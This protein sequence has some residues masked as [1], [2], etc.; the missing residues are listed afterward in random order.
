MKRNYLFLGL[1]LGVSC[2]IQVVAQNYKA[3]QFTTTSKAVWQGKRVPVR[4]TVVG[5]PQV[6]YKSDDVESTFQ[7][8]GTCFNELDWH[9]LARMPVRQIST[10]YIMKAM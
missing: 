10:I 1:L 3:L 4:S 8:W 7:A 6:V 2:S 5:T 9:A